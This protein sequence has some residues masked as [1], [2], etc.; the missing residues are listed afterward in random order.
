MLMCE[1]LMS[2]NLFGTFRAEWANIKK[3]WH[4]LGTLIIAK[5]KYHLLDKFI[6]C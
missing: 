2:D 4:S 3:L 5:F 1:M 6:I